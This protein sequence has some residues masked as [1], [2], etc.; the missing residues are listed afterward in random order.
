MPKFLRSVLQKNG[1]AEQAVFQVETVELEPPP[2]GHIQVKVSKAGVAFADVLQRL[3]LY[4]GVPKGKVTLGYDLVGTITAVG[5]GVSNFAIGDRVVALTVWS[6][7]QQ[8][9][10]I[11][12]EGPGRGDSF[13]PKGGRGRLALVPMTC[14]SVSDEKLVSLVLNYVTAYQMM[15]RSA[16]LHQETTRSLRRT[17]VILVHGAA[18]GVGT[19]MLQLASVYGIRCIGTASA[20]KHDLVR[21]LG[22]DPVD[23]SKKAWVEEVARLAGPEGVEAVFDPVGGSTTDTSYKV[24]RKNGAMVVL[25]RLFVLA[26]CAAGLTRGHTCRCSLVPPACT[27]VSRAS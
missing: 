21:R 6:A 10:N 9:V 8:Y 27:H 12:A 11:P 16:K 2:A 22:G 26:G 4:P 3:G 5:S 1:T 23:Y 18:G 19:A 13:T 14:S 25:Y 7:H 20:G 17:Q 24:L 15:F